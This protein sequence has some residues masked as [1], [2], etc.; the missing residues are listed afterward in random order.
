MRNR[1]SDLPLAYCRSETLD[2]YGTWLSV[3]LLNVTPANNRFE[4]ESKT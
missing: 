3:S 1:K 4:S 2:S